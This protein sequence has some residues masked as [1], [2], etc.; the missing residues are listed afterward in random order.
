M[1]KLSIGLRIGYK[2]TKYRRTGAH[3]LTNIHQLEVHLYN[4]K[5]VCLFKITKI[6]PKQKKKANNE[7]DN[8]LANSYKKAKTKQNFHVKEA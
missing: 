5:T 4:N 1:Y 3:A 2:S 6:H 7:G 8:E